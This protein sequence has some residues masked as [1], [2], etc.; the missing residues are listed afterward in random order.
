[1]HENESH[2]LQHVQSATYQGGS[3]FNELI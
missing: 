2:Y 1:M 3:T